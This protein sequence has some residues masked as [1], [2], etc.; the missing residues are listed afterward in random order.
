MIDDLNDLISRSFV[1]DVLQGDVF[2]L[3][4]CAL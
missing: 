1:S 3:A 2:D 4:D